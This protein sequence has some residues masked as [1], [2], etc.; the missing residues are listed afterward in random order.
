MATSQGS[1]DAGKKNDESKPTGAGGILGKQFQKMRRR[2]TVTGS[3]Q[4]IDG[5]LKPGAAPSD[6]KKYKGYKQDQV[7]AMSF[8]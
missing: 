6:S 7:S 2:L 4:N 3:T 5:S 8:S 1:T